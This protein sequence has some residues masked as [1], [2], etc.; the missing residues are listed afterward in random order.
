M[1]S[2]E[3]CHHCW[4]PAIGEAWN[5]TEQEWQPHCREC[6]DNQNPDKWEPYEEEENEG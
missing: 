5:Y 3:T 4:R 2:H 1:T 6:C